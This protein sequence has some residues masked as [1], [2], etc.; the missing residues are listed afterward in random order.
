MKIEICNYFS[1]NNI[2]FDV[3]FE[4]MYGEYRL[5]IQPELENGK[6]V[7]LH[8]PDS[9]D[10]IDLLPQSVDAEDLIAAMNEEIETTTRCEI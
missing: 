2:D 10:D 9:Q 5:F 4:G 7:S 8:T 3:V 1:E 6:V